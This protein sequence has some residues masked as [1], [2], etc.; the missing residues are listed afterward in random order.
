MDQGPEADAAVDRLARPASHRDHGA[1]QD[2]QDSPTAE[3]KMYK[4]DFVGGNAGDAGVGKE[5]HM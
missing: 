5:G 3:I 2:A 4:V 1:K